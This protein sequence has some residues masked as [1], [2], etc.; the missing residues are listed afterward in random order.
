MRF[1]TEITRR[2]CSILAFV[3]ITI[4]SAQSQQHNTI[5]A[6]GLKQGEWIIQGMMVKDPL[7]SPDSKVEEG[8]YI[9]NEKEG[10]WKKYWPNGTVRSEIHYMKGKPEGPYKVYYANGKL[11]ESGRWKDGKLCDRF[12]RYHSNGIV[13]E[14]FTYDSEGTRQGKQH[15]YHENGTLAMEVEMNGGEEHGVQ[16]RYDDRGQLM[17]ERNFDNGKSKPG[18][19]K[20]YMTP[21]Q[22]KASQMGAGSVGIAENQKTNGAQQFDPNGYNVLY[23]SNG[24]VCVSGDFLNGKLYNGKVNHYSADGLKTGTEIFSR[25]KSNGKLAADSN[26]Q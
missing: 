24:N 22:S 7:Y 1:S 11:E 25:G 18:G 15:Y 2:C 12:Q 4:Q 23:D 10:V 17:E 5:D 20:S 3:W 19:V 16:K 9:D 8:V 21:Q 26:N 13:K 6:R 14:D